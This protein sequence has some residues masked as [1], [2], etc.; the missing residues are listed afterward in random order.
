MT[1]YNE[2]DPH[3]AQ[4]LN[5]LQSRGLITLGQVDERSIT[6][7][8]STDVAGTVRV[9]LFAGIGGWDLALQLA[10]W[11]AGRPVWTGSC[12]CQ[13]FSRAGRRGG[14]ADPRHLWPEMFRLISACRPPFVFGEQV[15]GPDGRTWCA[16]VRADL[17]GIGYRFDALSI[18]AAAVG[19]PHVRERIYWGAERL[20]DARG[21]R[22]DGRT[23]D[24]GQQE[25]A[26]TRASGHGVAGGLADVSGFGRREGC[27]N[28]GW[29]GTGGPAPWDER[30]GPSDYGGPNRVA[31]PD[32]QR[33]GGID[34][35]LRADGTG[36]RAGEVSETAGRSGACGVGSPI[37]SGPQGQRPSVR[38]RPVH[39][40]LCEPTSQAG[41]AGFWSHSALVD[42]RDGAKRRVESGSFPLAHGLPRELGRGEPGLRRMA[43]G[44]RLNRRVRLKGYG[45]AIVPELAAMF[46]LAFMGW[47]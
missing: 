5:N 11:P 3:A 36:W 15:S 45:N 6:D 23:A 4:W 29:G 37:R 28:A 33:C 22:R 12:P 26:S 10:G 9:H 32:L 35:L 8:G 19:A 14:E 34:P 1:Y 30:V 21:E 41:G 7:V 18:C 40:G 44:A 24:A 25:G 20:P 13:P 46:I 43:G 38:G 47:Q 42:F 17:E 31:N 27:E 39:R 2:F 16:G